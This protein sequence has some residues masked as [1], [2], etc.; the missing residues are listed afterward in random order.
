MKL[1][2]EGHGVLLITLYY[3]GVQLAGKAGEQFF[4]GFLR[5]KRV[6]RAVV[7]AHLR[8]CVKSGAPP[9]REGACRRAFLP[10]GGRTG[11]EG[12]F[13]LHHCRA[14]KRFHLFC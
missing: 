2:A 3:A 13:V 5:Q 12:R 8:A 14:A 4:H 7:M 10:P 9:G 11:G 6:Y 1:A